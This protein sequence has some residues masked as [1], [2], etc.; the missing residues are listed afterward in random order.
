[1]SKIVDEFMLI[2]KTIPKYNVSTAYKRK[3]DKVRPVDPGSTDGSKPGGIPDWVE[4][5]KET[6]IK[7][8]MTRKYAKWLIPKFLD[9]EKGS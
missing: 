9:I 7:H 1:M 6:N 3:A 8:P 5:S 2:S 4:K